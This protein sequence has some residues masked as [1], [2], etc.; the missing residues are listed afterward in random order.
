[1]PNPLNVKLMSVPLVQRSLLPS[2]VKFISVGLKL[3]PGGGSS[4]DFSLML[5]VISY[6]NSDKPSVCSLL[7]RKPV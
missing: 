3:Q 2:T 6:L 1:M 5:Y 7:Y 4:Y